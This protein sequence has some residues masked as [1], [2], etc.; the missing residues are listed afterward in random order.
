MQA[1]NGSSMV[2]SH[3]L[4]RSS[5]MRNYEKPGSF[6]LARAVNDHSSPKPLSAF[7]NSSPRRAPSETKISQPL[8]Y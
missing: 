2:R 6:D 7:A 1:L 5:T 8:S 4:T 3:P